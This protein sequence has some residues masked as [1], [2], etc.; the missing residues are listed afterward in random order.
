[1]E[2]ALEAHHEAVVVLGRRAQVEV[3]ST[4]GS[5]LLETWFGWKGEGGRLPAVVAEWLPRARGHDSPGPAA[6][7]VMERGDRRLVVRLLPAGPDGSGEALLLVD[8]RLG[9]SP[10]AL[11]ALGLTDREAEV[12]ALVAGG[13][14]NNQVA[15][16]LSLSER[17]VQT[18]LSTIYRKLGVDNRTAAT[19]LAVSASLRAD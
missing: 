19:S 6:P 12:L 2:Q 4:R 11:A 10:A 9:L 8:E 1:M 5:R 17:T 7:L 14:T 16:Q 18:Y 13:R 3:A 15:R